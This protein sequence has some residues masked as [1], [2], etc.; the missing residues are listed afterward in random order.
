M[1]WLFDA[2]KKGKRR[3]VDVREETWC[4]CSGGERPGEEVLEHSRRRTGD[5]RFLIA[6]TER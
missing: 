2:V 5:A 3:E 1:E 4:Y 6:E